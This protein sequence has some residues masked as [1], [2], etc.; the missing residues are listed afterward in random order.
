M[1]WVTLRAAAWRPILAITAVV[2]GAHA[3][4]LAAAPGPVHAPDP[5]ANRTLITRVVVIAPPEPEAVAPPPQQQPSKRPERKRAVAL[6]GNAAPEAQPAVVE[7]VA[8][9][10]AEPAAPAV[11]PP[12]APAP[13]AREP[14]PRPVTFAIPGSVRLHYKVT[15]HSRNQNWQAD[16]ELT[17][18]H[19]GNDYDAK[20]SVTAPFLP[21]RTQ[22]STG[23]I[24]PEGLA[25]TRFSDKGRNEEAAHFERDK[26]KVSFSSNRPDA[27]L[28][29]GAQDR[30]S[31]MLQLGAMI[32]GEPAKYGPATTISIQTAST[33]DAEIWLFTVEGDEQLQLPGGWVPA[34]K[35]YATRAR[36]STRR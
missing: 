2:L 28:M 4:L 26:G 35:L 3:L 18:R 17:W 15:A 29:A 33:R 10:A 32:A 31:V 1:A 20:L 16:G 11:K 34:L 22:Q 36:S 27:A 8:A 5:L 7:Q 21:T 9:T 12:P 30:L 24:G 19:D 23:K 25:P 14:G 13:P 6:N